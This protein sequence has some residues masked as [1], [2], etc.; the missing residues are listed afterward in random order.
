MEGSSNFRKF[1]AMCA[2]SNRYF[3]KQSSG[4]PDTG[5]PGSVLQ[6]FSP[7]KAKM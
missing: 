4:G 5:Q 7:N 6:Y 3:T 1:L 2:S